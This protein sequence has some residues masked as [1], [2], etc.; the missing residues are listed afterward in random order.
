MKFY[1]SFDKH[2][3]TFSYQSAM[4][5]LSV[6]PL[7]L[8]IERWLLSV[9]P[10]ASEKE[11]ADFEKAALEFQKKEGTKLQAMLVAKSFYSTNYVSDWWEKYVYLRG[12]SPILINSVMSSI[13]ISHGTVLP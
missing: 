4:P 9:K 6:P 11:Y 2:P 1:F 5:R 13:F 3:L 8:T 7:K 12:R 10:V